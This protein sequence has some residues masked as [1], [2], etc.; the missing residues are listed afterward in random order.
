MI[1]ATSIGNWPRLSAK[2]S[3]ELRDVLARECT[4]VEDALE[5]LS[6]KINGRTRPSTFVRSL[7][8]AYFYEL[9]KKRIN[10][11]YRRL[12]AFRHGQALIARRG[13]ARSLVT[14]ST[15]HQRSD[16]RIS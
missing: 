8:I 10:E 15:H 11:H 16:G 12:P 4:G 14:V 1:R 9:M 3:V 5:W 2:L 13:R 6:T 7:S